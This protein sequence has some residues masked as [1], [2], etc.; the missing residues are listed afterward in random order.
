MPL[1]QKRRPRS[2]SLVYLTGSVFTAPSAVV[3]NMALFFLTFAWKRGGAVEEVKQ[4]KKNQ[5]KGG[6]WQVDGKEGTDLQEKPP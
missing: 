4:K 2:S 3:L 5:Q 6:R 1:T